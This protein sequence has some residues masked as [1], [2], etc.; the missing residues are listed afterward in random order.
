MKDRF[1]A[2]MSSPLDSKI[3]V[4][5]NFKG[6]RNVDE[7][8]KRNKL[9]ITE[10]Q[11][12]V[13]AINVQLFGRNGDGGSIGAINKALDKL[14]DGQEKLLEKI[15]SMDADHREAHARFDGRLNQADAKM[16]AAHERLDEQEGRVECLEKAPAA[17]R[18]TFDKILMRAALSVI[19]PGGLVLLGY[20]LKVWLGA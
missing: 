9:Y 20:G 1:D 3:C 12:D 11:R 13:T 15:M 14:S 4:Q 7:E 17:K 6:E 8:D 16:T 18:A 10:L 19:V 5:R 2:I